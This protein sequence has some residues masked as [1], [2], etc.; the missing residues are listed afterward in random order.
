MRCKFLAL[1]CLLALNMYAQDDRIILRNGQELSVKITQIDIDKVYYQASNQKNALQEVLEFKDVY[2]LHTEL[3]GNV[4][5]SIDGKRRTGEK[6]KLDPKA[7]LIYLVDGGEIPGYD[8]ELNEDGMLCFMREIPILQG[9]KKKKIFH[10][11]PATL[12]ATDVF[13][14]KYP[15]GT[16]DIINRFEEK[17]EQENLKGDSIPAEETVGEFNLVVINHKVSAGETLATIAERY[18]VSVEDIIEWND[19][20]STIRPKSRLKANLQLVIYAKSNN[21]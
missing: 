8:V 18:E 16:R 21:K 9:T 5:I 15:D 12:A 17:V 6:H 20:S 7:T 4:Y 10:R 11:V 2:M 14:I 19:L 3:R 13:M 1:S